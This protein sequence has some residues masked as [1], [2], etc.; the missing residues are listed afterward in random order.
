[1]SPPVA[2]SSAV[3]STLV[4]LSNELPGASKIDDI[5]GPTYVSEEPVA[6]EQSPASQPTK[7][8]KPK[9]GKFSE[10]QDLILYMLFL[11]SLRTLRTTGTS[12]KNGKTLRGAPRL[13]RFA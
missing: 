8:S 1:M 12:E 13:L 3:L 5:P 10:E 9:R 4:S 11:G 7:S 2:T 6:C